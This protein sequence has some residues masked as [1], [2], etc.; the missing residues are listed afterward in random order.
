MIEIGEFV[1]TK[2]GRIAILN[3]AIE[4]SRWC[5][6]KDKNIY[7]TTTYSIT[8]HSKNIIDLIEVGD[9]I[10][11][12]KIDEIIEK[13]KDIICFRYKYYLDKDDVYTIKREDIKTVLTHEIYERNCH[14]VEE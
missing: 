13:N 12:V 5:E 11:G 4:K 3:K 9:F 2:T 1:R 14:E 6:I 10:N 8:K 7:E